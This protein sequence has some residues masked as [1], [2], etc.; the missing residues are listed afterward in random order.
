MVLYNETFLTHDNKYNFK[1]DPTEIGDKL[2]KNYVMFLS[3]LYHNL[4]PVS[5]DKK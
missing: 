1:Q 5:K 2:K 4:E 3:Y